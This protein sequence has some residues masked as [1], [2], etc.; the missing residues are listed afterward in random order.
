MAGTDLWQNFESSGSV[1]EY[2]RYKS[3]QRR[4][5]LEEKAGENRADGND[6][7][8]AARSESG[9]GRPDINDPDP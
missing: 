4:A 1:S 7:D 5:A 9:R 2:L 6:R 3:S 8:S